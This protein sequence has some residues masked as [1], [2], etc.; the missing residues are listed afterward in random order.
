[1]AAATRALLGVALALSASFPLRAEEP[2]PP[3]PKAHFNDYAGV[4]SAADAQRLDARLAEFEKQTSTQI[5]VAVFPKLTWPD[6]DEF[7]NRT[8]QAW[9][10]GQKKLDN[11]AVLFVFVEDRRMKIEVGY[12]L[13]GALPDQLA[14]RILDLEVR[15]RF[16]QGDWVGGLTAGIDA[17]MA[18]T[19]GEYK[20]Q[21]PAQK[22]KGTSGLSIVILLAFLLLFLWLSSIGSRAFGGRTYGRGGWRGGGGGFWGGGWGGGGGGGWSSGGGGGGFSGGGGSFGGGGASS[23]W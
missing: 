15:P 10:V 1:M 4:V 22:A 11:G 20:A 13:E 3:P 16:R 23:S 18:A 6:L 9:G 7:T 12:G 2:L 14:A 17:M 8:A 19:R 21:A 5:V